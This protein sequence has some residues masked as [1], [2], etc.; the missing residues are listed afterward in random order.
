MT[1]RA[2]I[3]HYPEG[4]S[5]RVDKNTLGQWVAAEKLPDCPRC[6]QDELIVHPLSGKLECLLDGCRWPREAASEEAS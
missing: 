1:I 6:G 4:V 2:Y 3:T 5:V